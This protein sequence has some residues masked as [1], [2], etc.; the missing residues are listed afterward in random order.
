M[1]V[2]NRSLTD[3]D[4][5]TDVESVVSNVSRVIAYRYVYSDYFPRFQTIMFMHQLIEAH[6]NTRSVYRPCGFAVRA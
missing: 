1:C 4:R 2:Q 6:C 5:S 3:N